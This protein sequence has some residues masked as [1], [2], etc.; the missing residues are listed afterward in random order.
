LADATEACKP[1]NPR[2][3]GWIKVALKQADKPGHK[4]NNKQ[5]GNHP[6]KP[7]LAR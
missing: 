2:K 7:R 6:G 1:F 3:P 4:I 5:G